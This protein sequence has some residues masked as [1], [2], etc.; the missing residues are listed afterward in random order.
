MLCAALN[1]QGDVFGS[2][3]KGSAF[4]RPPEPFHGF[5]GQRQVVKR[6]KA[7]ADGALAQG[8]PLPHMLFAGPTG[9]GKT[10]LAEALATDYGSSFS[11]LHGK[12]DP[13]KLCA[14]LASQQNGDTILIDES[15][16]LHGSTQELLYTV[17]DGKGW[18][19]DHLGANAPNAKRNAEQKLIVPPITLIFATNKVNKLQQTTIR[20][21]RAAGKQFSQHNDRRKSI[22][23]SWRNYGGRW[24]CLLAVIAVLVVLTMTKPTEAAHRNAI[25]ERTPIARA[26]FAVQEVV[27]GAELN[28]HDYYVCS[29]MT[30]RF[31]KNERAI[32][33]SIGLFGNVFYGTES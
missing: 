21:L 10:K 2:A 25:A 30:A 12:C 3:Q 17:L 19:E 6:L 15:Q 8:K 27:G 14:S 20:P 11:V 16:A 24:V 13:A 1:S 7:L 23:S 22:M 5:I 9:F 4:M 29:V 26:L 31:G 33:I 28:Y 18:V 32:P